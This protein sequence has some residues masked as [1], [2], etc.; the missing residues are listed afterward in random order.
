MKSMILALSLSLAAFPAL[1]GNS[2]LSL[3][4][5]V[6]LHSPHLSAAERAQLEKYLDGDSAAAVAGKFSVTA[7]A[8]TCRMGDVDITFHTCD[9][10]FGAK[11]VALKGRQAH[12]L[13][14]T[15]IENGVPSD[16]AAGSIYEA[17]TNLDCVIAP[18]EIKENA[19]G[20][21]SCKFKSSK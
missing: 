17:L 6:G 8:V 15:L 7:H 10:D 20:G 3:A 9:L 14:A 16:G 4:A 21:A 2:E 1:A 11:Q 12:E 18:A 5:L 13:Y 19:G